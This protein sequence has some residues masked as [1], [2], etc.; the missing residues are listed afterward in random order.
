MPGDTTTPIINQ[1][2]STATSTLDQSLPAKQDRDV[3]RSNSI[4]NIESGLVAY[5]ADNKTYPMVNDFASMILSIKPYLKVAVRAEDPINKDPYVYTY[6]PN[7]DGSDFSL[8]FYSE[9]AGQLIK[10]TAADAAKDAAAEEAAIYDNQRETDLDTLRTT[11][12]LYSQ[13]NIA[14]NQD[15]VF[16]AKDKY[17]TALVPDLLSAI[18]KDP[19]TGQDYDYQV[20][21]TF[22]A[23]TLKAVL[24][25]PPPGNTGY[26]CNQEE[27]CHFY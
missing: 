10:K 22:D 7:A 6:T 18:P 5:Y 27:D 17:K 25:N 16:P 1:S 13:K 19:V 4:K 14:G 12:L 20:S 15:Y 21:G 2:T 23:F 9:L 11:L 24:Q 8:T 3:Q 26:I